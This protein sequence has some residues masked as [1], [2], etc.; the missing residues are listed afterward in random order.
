MKEKVRVIIS[1]VI[2][3]VLLGLV[4]TF[5]I[6]EWMPTDTSEWVRWGAMAL[7]GAYAIYRIASL[8]KLLEKREE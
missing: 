1:I 4:V 3:A 5:C 2:S 7:C 8:A 6:R